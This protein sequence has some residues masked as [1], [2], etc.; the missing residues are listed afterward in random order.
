MD[1]SLSG[2]SVP[3]ILQARILEWV[4]FSCSKGSSNPGIEP[5]SP[6]LQVDSLSSESPGKPRVGGRVSKYVNF[7]EILFKLCKGR[8]LKQINR[9]HY[10]TYW[11]CKKKKKKK[12]PEAQRHNKK[13]R[14]M[15]PCVTWT[16]GVVALWVFPLQASGRG[17][18][19]SASHAR[20]M[21]DTRGR[22]VRGN[23]E[24]HSYSLA[25]TRHLMH[26]LTCL[27]PKQCMWWS[28]G[29]GR[30]RVCSQGGSVNPKQWAGMLNSGHISGGGRGGDNWDYD[31]IYNMHFQKWIMYFLVLKKYWEWC[32]CCVCFMALGHHC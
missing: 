14:V 6:A 7:H 11:M 25:W 22:R 12:T 24:C 30:G 32:H 3:G 13:G 31:L 20:L 10:E 27:W 29:L 5:R 9:N 26:L 18:S 23:L 28:P 16:T 17:S 4:A 15:S 8:S 19:P 21:T 1:C 2:S